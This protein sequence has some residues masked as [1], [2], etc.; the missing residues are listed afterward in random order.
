MNTN[1]RWRK[2][3]KEFRQ[4]LRPSGPMFEVPEF[5][6]Y[7][8]CD[9][10]EQLYSTKMSGCDFYAL[11]RV[12][13]TEWNDQFDG[14]IVTVNGIR[15]KLPIS[16]LKMLKDHVMPTLNNSYTTNPA[17]YK[18]KFIIGSLHKTTGGFSMTASPC[19]QPTRE[20]AK[21]EAARLA[22]LDKTKMFVVLNVTDI[23]SVQDVVFL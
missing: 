2:A 22:A 19:R 20:A 9:S 18:N 5:P 14:F 21:A 16:F 3:E 17:D 4:A 13:P 15:N 23:A 10:Q 7:V 12:M 11:K 6:Q 1:Y 8:Y